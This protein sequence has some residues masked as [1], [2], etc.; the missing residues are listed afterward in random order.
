[1]ALHSDGVYYIGYWYAD[2]AYRFVSNCRN[3][4]EPLEIT[5]NL[6]AWDVERT[7]DSFHFWRNCKVGEYIC[8]SLFLHLPLFI[9]FFFVL[10]KFECHNIFWYFTGFRYSFISIENSKYCNIQTILFSHCELICG[11]FSKIPYPF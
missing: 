5:N 11:T 3:L 2:R 8:L 6:V 1:M 7:F 9:M 10:Y 4:H